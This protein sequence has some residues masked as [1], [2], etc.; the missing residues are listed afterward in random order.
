MTRPRIKI[1]GVRDS[2]T[3]QVVASAGADY[4]GLS[5]IEASPRYVTI[6]QAR[7]IVASLPD[8]IEPVGL[9]VD[10]PVDQ[11]KATC[12]DVGLSIVQL[13]GHE[14]P[15]VVQQ[16]SPLRVIQALPFAGESFAETVDPWR[17]VSSELQAILL[18]AP[19]S[20][21]DSL[22]G[23]L[24]RVLD[25]SALAKCQRSGLFDDLPAM[26]L[27]G[28][29]NPQNVAQAIAITKPYAVDVSSGVESARGV[30]DADLIATF[31]R[32][33]DGQ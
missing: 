33:C 8:R 22:T 24:G 4:I 31:C 28:G 6:E 3:A 27:A 10:H 16:L 30:K 20:D 11:I 14:T 25:W 15:S 9:F 1:C 29:L 32:A 18:D 23:G 12:N 7:A 21:S 19:P 17:E 13:H 5:F 26:F 2:A